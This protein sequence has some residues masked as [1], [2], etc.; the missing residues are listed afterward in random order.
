MFKKLEHVHIITPNIEESLKFY[1]EILG[2]K[3]TE[4][5]IIRDMSIAVL[6]LNDVRTVELIEIK[7]AAPIPE[8]RQVGYSLMALIVEDMEEAIN[9]LKAHNVKI[10]REPR[11]MSDEERGGF[12]GE[13]QDNNGVSIEIRQ[14]G[15]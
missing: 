14:L 1:T 5:R 8:K 13:F 11:S 10:T 9:H 6:S 12:R 2:F 4:K 7:D 3:I 15:K